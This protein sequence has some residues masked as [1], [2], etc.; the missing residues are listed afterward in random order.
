VVIVNKGDLLFVQGL[1]EPKL[2]LL[3]T[4]ETQFMSTA[5]PTGF[6]FVKDNQGKVTQLIVRGG[7]RDQTATRK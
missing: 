7:E 1:N 6:E 5:T 4:S 3:A 2:P